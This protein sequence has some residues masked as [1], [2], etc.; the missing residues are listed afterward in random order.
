MKT[1][2]IPEVEECIAKPR[3]IGCKVILK[4]GQG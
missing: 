2:D 3:V 4:K 1:E